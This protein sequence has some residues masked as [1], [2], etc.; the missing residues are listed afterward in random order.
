MDD[1]ERRDGPWNQIALWRG[2]LGGLIGAAMAVAGMGWSLRGVVDDLHDAAARIEQVDGAAAQRHGELRG[3]IQEARAE[4]AA[5]ETEFRRTGG[6]SSSQERTLE[7]RLTLIE[8]RQNYV[9]RALDHI[10]SKTRQGEAP[11]LGS[12]YDPGA[13]RGGDGV[14]APGAP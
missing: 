11:P 3:M 12:P 8:E 10:L 9:L 7:R 4:I 2:L 5:L 6:V 14:D 13:G 1:D